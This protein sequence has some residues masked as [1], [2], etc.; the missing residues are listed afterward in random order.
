MKRQAGALAGFGGGRQRHRAEIEQFW[1]QTLVPFSGRGLR[2][3]AVAATAF[4]QRDRPRELRA[5]FQREGVFCQRT[6]LARFVRGTF[7]RAN[8]F[9]RRGAA[10][11]RLKPIAADWC[12]GLRYLIFRRKRRSGPGRR[13]PRPP[14]LRPGDV[15]QKELRPAWSAQQN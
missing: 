14:W 13:S 3:I 8:G 9:Y 1:L 11:E 6:D 2:R 15:P 7:G 10:D 5:G 4:D 12:T